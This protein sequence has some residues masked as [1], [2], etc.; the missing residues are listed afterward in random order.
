MRDK[1]ECVDALRAMIGLAVSELIRAGQAPHSEN[2]LTMLQLIG[3]G[4][5]SKSV[6]MLCIRARDLLQNRVTH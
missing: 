1:S 6:K 5:G 3:A 4:S 2:I